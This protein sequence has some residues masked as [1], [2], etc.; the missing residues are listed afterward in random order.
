MEIAD[1]IYLFVY[2]LLHV[3]FGLHMVVFFNK[4]PQVTAPAGCFSILNPPG[5]RMVLKGKL[6]P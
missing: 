3:T 2:F 5:A 6:Q 1:F 4:G